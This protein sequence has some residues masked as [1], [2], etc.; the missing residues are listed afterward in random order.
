[1]A[2]CSGC[3][4]TVKYLLENNA[5]LHAV[6]INGDSV[7]HYAVREGELKL[8]RYFIDQGIAANVSN[9]AGRTGLHLAAEG[10]Y[11]EIVNL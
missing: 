9:Y 10:G 4:T 5:Y 1:M 8:A 6:D 3:F 2:A 7:L 11:I